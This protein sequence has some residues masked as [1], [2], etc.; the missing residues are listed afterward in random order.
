MQYKKTVLDNG[1]TIITVPQSASVATTVLVMVATGSKYEEKKVN[2]ISHFLEHMCFKG[3]EK[4]PTAFDI[5]SELDGLGAV[6]NAFTSQEWTGYFAKV[7][8]TH[9]ER[10]LDIVSDIYLNPVF[11]ASEIEKEKGVIVEEISMYKDMP[12][13]NIYDNFMELLYGDQPA[14]WGIAGTKEIVKSLTREE[15][16]TYREAHYV[17]SATTVVI[18]GGFDEEKMISLSKELFS[19]MQ[20]KEKGSKLM[21]KEEQSTPAVNLEYK[22]SDQAHIMI[23]Y[24]AFGITDKRRYALDVASAVLGSGMSSR[25]F[26]VIRDQMGAAYYV[27][28]DAD[29]YTDHGY[30]SVN[31]GAELSKTEEVIKAVLV[32]FTKLA[33]SVV[34][35]EELNKVKNHLAGNLLLGLETSDKMSFYYGV[36][37]ILEP[38]LATPEEILSRIKSVTPEQIK[39]VMQELIKPES[40]NLAVIGPFKDKEKFQ[41]LLR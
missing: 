8:K 26:Q 27:H 32:E 31:V 13:R 6:N 33:N 2:G 18:A 39:R 9:G 23:G 21:V 41:K 30:V 17:P 3:T 1:L 36:Q 11:D 24:R 10:A 19:K 7:D 14:G 38:E 4:R 35:D 28:A 12:Q 20:S 25:L 29:L 22:D 40:L 34:S 16:I 37:N 15:F 5:T